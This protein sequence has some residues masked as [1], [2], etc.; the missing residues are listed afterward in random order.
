MFDIDIR[1]TVELERR[2]ELLKEAE[3]DRLL[4]ETHRQHTTATVRARLGA[5]LI[6][7]GQHISGS[8]QPGTPETQPRAS[9]LVHTTV[10]SVGPSSHSH[11]C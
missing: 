3:R 11:A 6:H 8:A 7:I 1:R 4:G 9:S 2:Q 10:E 5:T